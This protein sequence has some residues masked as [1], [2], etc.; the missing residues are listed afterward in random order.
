MIGPTR[1]AAFEAEL[2]A[3]GY[4]AVFVTPARHHPMTGRDV[5]FHPSTTFATPDRQT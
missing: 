1:A 2:T 5:S 4:G 3:L